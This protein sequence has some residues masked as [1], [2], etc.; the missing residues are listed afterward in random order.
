MTTIEITRHFT[1]Q[2]V[3][4]R[5]TLGNNEDEGHAAV[6]EYP[7]PAGY[8]VQGGRICDPSG[9]ECAIALG[10]YGG[11]VL[12]SRAGSHPDA[13]LRPVQILRIFDV[14]I[15]PETGEWLGEA[16][17]SG[18][19]TTFHEWCRKSDTDE[20]HFDRHTAWTLGGETTTRYPGP[21]EVQDEGWSETE[22]AIRAR[23]A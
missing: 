14:E 17:D 22:V 13:I 18:E 21:F 1:V 4:D 11:P 16:L 5:F 6:T 23:F 8:I 3:V 10:P 12:M 7:L 15:D 2:N 20:H 9:I 19:T